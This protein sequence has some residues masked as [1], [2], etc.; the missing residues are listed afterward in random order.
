MRIVRR[1][2]C[3]TLRFLITHKE[4]NEA[5]ADIRTSREQEEDRVKMF[6]LPLAVDGSSWDNTSE[7]VVKEGGIHDEE[8]GFVEKT[9]RFG[10]FC[11]AV[12]YFRARW[13]LRQQRKRASEFKLGWKVDTGVPVR[14][15]RK[16]ISQTT[17]SS[18]QPGYQRVK[19]M[20][21]IFAL[22]CSIITFQADNSSSSLATL[23]QSVLLLRKCIHMKFSGYLL[24]LSSFCLVTAGTKGEGASRSP[25][26]LRRFC[27]SREE[28]ARC[29]TTHTA[30]IA[31]AYWAQS[32]ISVA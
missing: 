8:I 20:H 28:R 30:N 26:R 9:M 19:V 6:T 24:R 7:K 16:P 3:A 25:G 18:T 2:F 17:I 15:Q 31:R 14:A 1:C 12:M 21:A 5:P 10:L 23:P 32:S 27:R 4:G 22:L 13:L 29:G 11:V